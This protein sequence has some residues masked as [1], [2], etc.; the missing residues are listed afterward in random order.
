[1]INKILLIILL[2]FMSYLKFSIQTSLD[3]FLS[4]CL[5]DFSQVIFVRILWDYL[6]QVISQDIF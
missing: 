6:I 2:I 4:Y 3:E 1:M 5:D